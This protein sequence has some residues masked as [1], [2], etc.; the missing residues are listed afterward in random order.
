MMLRKLF[1]GG[2]FSEVKEDQPRQRHMFVLK[3]KKKNILCSN[4][5][6]LRL[7]RDYTQDDAEEVVYWWV[8]S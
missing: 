2:L 4:Y 5:F 3:D 7:Q 8:V 1:I 6:R